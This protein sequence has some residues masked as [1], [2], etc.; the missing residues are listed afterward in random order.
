MIRQESLCDRSTKNT[1]CG[2]TQEVFF[3]LFQWFTAQL[4]I[5]FPAGSI[6]SHGDI[7]V[8]GKVV[9]EQQRK[10]RQYR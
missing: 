3:D 7:L 10:G 8:F 1:S 2:K 9:E 6:G 4:E 5:L